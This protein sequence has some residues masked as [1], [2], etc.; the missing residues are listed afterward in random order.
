VFHFDPRNP[1]AQL[2]YLKLIRLLDERPGAPAEAQDA[3]HAGESI[4]P[5]TVS[6]TRYIDFLVPGLIAMGIM[7]SSLWGMSYGVVEKRS[8]KLLRRM[9][10]TPM[11]KSHFL[12]ALMTVRTAM[13][14]IEG[15]LL[16]LFAY[17]VFHIT[18][19]G[20]V[21]ALVLI[22]LSGNVAF[23]GIAILTSA[24]TG[25]TEIA[26][27]LINLVS[28]PMMVLSGIFFSYHNF[29]EWSLPYIQKLPLTMLADGMRS[30]FIEGAGYAGIAFP[31]IV[32]ALLGVACFAAGLK[33]FRWY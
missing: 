14:F 21:P 4:E 11:K 30:I 17:L 15:G 26:N 12:I 20:N 23:A 16:F 19:Q 28:L 24:R 2:T 29:P 32:L 10:A 7:M 27:G 3:G 22:F 8:K 33:I 5:L 18:I 9:V 13:N 25:N 1:D 6:G 31:S